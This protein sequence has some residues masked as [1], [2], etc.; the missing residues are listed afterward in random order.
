MILIAACGIIQ[1]AIRTEH[2]PDRGH[3]RSLAIEPVS[4]GPCPSSICSEPGTGRWRFLSRGHSRFLWS[5]L[6][7]KPIPTSMRVNS[8]YSLPPLRRHVAL[9]CQDRTVHMEHTRRP[10]SNQFIA[11]KL[12]IGRRRARQRLPLA[13]ARSRHARPYPHRG[14]VALKQYHG[15]PSLLPGAKPSVF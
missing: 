7:P 11:A 15:R 1:V 12:E 5:D 10:R 13:S 6:P 4:S 14:R 8:L 3:Q 2:P 9:T